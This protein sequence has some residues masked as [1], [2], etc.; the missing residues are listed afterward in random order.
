MLIWWNTA[1]YFNPH[2]KL[3]RN[4]EG[5]RPRYLCHLYKYFNLTV[6]LICRLQNIKSLANYTTSKIDYVMLKLKMV[7]CYVVEY[8]CFVIEVISKRQAYYKYL[9]EIDMLFHILSL[10]QFLVKYLKYF[11]QLSVASKSLNATYT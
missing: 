6:I 1:N 4:G 9:E 5:G 2:D 7:D 8:S 11:L 10:L 3:M